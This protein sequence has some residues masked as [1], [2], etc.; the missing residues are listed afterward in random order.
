MTIW[1]VQECG[2]SYFV[3]FDSKEKAE[4][5][6]SKNYEEEDRDMAVFIYEKEVL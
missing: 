6:F 1:V 5:Y 3:A 4:Q 2:E